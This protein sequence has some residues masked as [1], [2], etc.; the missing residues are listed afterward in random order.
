[1]SEQSSD[2]CT[3][4]VDTGK[5]LHCVVSRRPKAGEKQREVL[6]IGTRQHYSELDELMRRFNVRRCVIDALPEIHATRE[7]ANR[8]S[9]P[10]RVAEAR[11]RRQAHRA[12]RVV[13]T[14]RDSVQEFMG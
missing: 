5:E 1:M 14:S 3:M 13:W 2:P 9:S 8:K 10:Y 6:F 11:R 12:R 7:F 4:G